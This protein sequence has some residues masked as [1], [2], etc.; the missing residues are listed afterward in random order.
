MSCLWSCCWDGG[1]TIF[2]LQFHDD[3]ILFLPLCKHDLA[4]TNVQDSVV[5]SLVEDAGCDVLQWSLTYLGV[6]SGCNF[7]AHS[8]LGSLDILNC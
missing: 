2:H 5:G 3:T 4:R 8:L 1:L 6:P 7:Y